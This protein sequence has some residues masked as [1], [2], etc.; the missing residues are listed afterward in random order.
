[1]TMKNEKE[2]A[3]AVSPLTKTVYAGM[4]KH[5]GSGRMEAVGARHDVTRFMPGVVLQYVG[6]ESVYV[7]D[8]GRIF[9]V[10]CQ[11][12]TQDEFEQYKLEKE[13]K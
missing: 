13:A 7:M 5:L 9:K 6:K 2:F 8:D 3:L 11:E 4:V 12:M 10:V 1:M